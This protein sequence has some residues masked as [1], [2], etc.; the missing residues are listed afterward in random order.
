MYLKINPT[1]G[2]PVY[3]Q[4]V[5][6]IKHAISIGVFEVGKSIPTIRDI[7]LELCVNPN[8]VAKAIRELEREGVL[9]TYVGKGSFVTEKSID[10][11]KKDKEFKIMQLIEKCVKDAKWIGLDKDS[12]INY[13][14][15][16]WEKV[17]LG[18]D[19]NEQFN[20]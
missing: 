17:I 4:I 13:I 8:T 7:A 9:K 1:S 3:L 2:I 16:N 18:G 20:S 5:E 19:E 14:N 10:I 15:E 6:Q 11:T 12:F